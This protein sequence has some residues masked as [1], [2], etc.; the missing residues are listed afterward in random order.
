MKINQCTLYLSLS[1]FLFAVFFIIPLLDNCTMVEGK[2]HLGVS[3]PLSLVGP[4]EKDRILEKQLEAALQ[5]YNMYESREVSLLRYIGS[6]FLSIP[7]LL[8]FTL[9]ILCCK[10]WRIWPSSLCTR[11]ASNLDSLQNR[12][13]WQAGKSW[14]LVVVDW[15]F[16]QP[17]SDQDK[18]DLQQPLS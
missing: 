6:P 15:V 9:G 1:P 11:Q 14:L 17:V 16:K 7:F 5:K 12:L 2:V 18:N 3:Q 13:A 8:T 10:S 4:S